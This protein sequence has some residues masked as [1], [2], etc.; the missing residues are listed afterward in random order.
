MPES[1]LAAIA[2]VD[3]D[4]FAD[5]VAAD[6]RASIELLG[7]FRG[8][9][10]PL[11]AEYRGT[12]VDVTNDELLVMFD[13]VLS[14]LQFALH[15][16]L[17]ARSMQGREGQTSAAGTIRDP[18]PRAG[19]HLGE[20]WRDGD[21]YFGN[22]VNVAA[23][24]MQ[25]ARAFQVLLSEDAWRQVANKLDLAARELPRAGLK[26]I[27]RDLGVWEVLEDGSAPVAPVV[28]DASEGRPAG[29]ADAD[30]RRIVRERLERALVRRPEP[31]PESVPGSE[32]AAGAEGT[33]GDDA[34]PARDDHRRNGVRIDVRTGEDGSRTLSFVDASSGPG[35]E[36]ERLSKARELGLRRL[37]RSLLVAALFGSYGLRIDSLWLLGAAVF[38]G[39]LP[40]VSGLRRALEA[41][42][43]LRA[44]DRSERP[45]D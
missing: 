33:L 5:L 4:G 39:L 45:H 10:E 15:L 29:T 13:S 37:V 36:R 23:R 28:S 14:A 18:A 20:V 43:K 32:P 42:S 9:A 8:L 11:V 17:A 27:E 41:G 1:R 16:R 25:A 22:G 12:I 2:F 19:I 26:N 31:E 21:R 38:G 7:R 24:V 44:L 34:D 6:E 30:R 3:L 35:T 40:A